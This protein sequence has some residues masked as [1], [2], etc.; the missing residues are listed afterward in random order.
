MAGAGSKA[1]LASLPLLLA[2]AGPGAAQAPTLAP[3]EQ[4]AD[5][6]VY[7][8]T[9]AGVTAA[10]AAKQMGKSVL[11]VCAEDYVGGM[12]SNGL[13]WTDTG[14][15]RAVG[16]L[17][18]G[19]YKRV[20]A[21]YDRP[22]AWRGGRRPKSARAFVSGGA[23][24]IFEPHVAE[25]VYDRWLRETGVS[26]VF[27]A[28]LDRGAGGV[29][30]QGATIRGFRSEDGRRFAGRVLIDA[31]Y[32]GDLMAAAGVSFTIG[33]EANARYGETLDGVELAKTTHHQFDRDID[34]YRVAGHP[35]SG[36]L[37][38]VSYRKL[39]PDGSADD[40]V[41]AYMYRL[42]L[43]DVAANQVPLPRPEGYDPGD[44]ELLARYLAAG[45]DEVF[46]LFSRL[47]NGKTDVNNWGAFSFDAIGMSDAYPTAGYAER[48]RILAA[49]RRYQQ[50]LLWFLGHDPRV[51][52]KIRTEMNR[53][54]LSRDEFVR[55]GNWPREIYV[56][57]G[58]RMVSDF[59]MAEPHI[60]GAKPT[61]DPIGMGSYAMDS[62]NVQRIVDAR[63]FARNE[64]NIE[65]HPDRP[66]PISYRAIVP[67]AA[68][69]DNLLVPAALSASHIAYGSI[70]ME[71]V[72]MIL[73]ESAGIAAAQ[74]IDEGRGVQAIDT[75]RL[76][77]TLLRR[78]QILKLRARAGTKAG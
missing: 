31:S 44:Y 4:R 37:P 50:G 76:R 16:G 66:Y 43:T 35:E 15:H 48:A 40:R 13:G 55:N 17:A 3:G 20:K 75:A 39:P 63:G 59:V 10:I 65:V 30:R 9:S 32:E 8:C 6:L 47:P 26:P 73:G 57:E 77:R 22:F 29:T 41:Q 78:G 60:L 7:G 49:H 64:G 67:K 24:W 38:Y 70:R 33:R 1:A 5:I 56:R 2:L 27:N 46:G 52:A 51:P 72:F 23:Q 28:R 18:L 34:P 68:E 58:R 61:P 36:L 12:T 69:A 19:F 53:W 45:F 42:C 62:H 25:Q 11:L 74:A 54:G 71:P 21:V 14:N